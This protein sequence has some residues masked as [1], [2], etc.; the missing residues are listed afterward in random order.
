MGA[1]R[2]VQERGCLALTL[3]AAINSSGSLTGTRNQPLTCWR[4]ATL[5]ERRVVGLRQRVIRRKGDEHADAALPLGLLRPRRERPCCRRAA[6]QRDEL[7]TFHGCPLRSVGLWKDNTMRADESAW[8][9]DRPGPLRGPRHDSEK[10]RGESSARRCRRSSERITRSRRPAAGRT[11]FVTR[12]RKPTTGIFRHSARGRHLRP[13][14]GV[15]ARSVE[16]RRYREVS[17]I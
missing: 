8:A 7:A 9:K 17:Q 6:E 3:N 2:P 1:S 11:T 10:A 12:G 16:R 4:A 14:P 13:G 5:Q 15:Q